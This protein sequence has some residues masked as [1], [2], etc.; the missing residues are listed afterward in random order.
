MRSVR[1]RWAATMAALII[2]LGVSTPVASHAAGTAAQDSI[3][4]GDCEDAVLP[5][6]IVPPE[7]GLQ[8]GCSHLYTLK[9]GAGHGTRGT[10]GI[11][12]LPPCEWNFC[13]APRIRNRLRCELV[14]GNA[15]C[16]GGDFIGT[17]IPNDPGDRAGLFLPAMLLRWSYD[18]DQRKNICHYDYL[19][20]GKRI[21]RIVVLR[22]NDANGKKLMVVEGFAYFF[23]QRLP[24]RAGDDLVGEFLP[25]PP[26]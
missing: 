14:H 15:C 1:A 20:N 19:G 23:I 10:Y 6:G 3:I 13:S 5:L 26:Q 18:T 25:A 2:S 9:Y 24:A 16:S 21:I 17:Q 12:D 22:P 8:A 7:G 4:T 11:V